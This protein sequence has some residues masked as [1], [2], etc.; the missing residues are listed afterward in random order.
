[1]H[2]TIGAYAINRNTAYSKRSSTWTSAEAIDDEYKYALAKRASPF[3]RVS[4]V[5]EFND[6]DGFLAKVFTDDALDVLN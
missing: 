4:L 3:E 6:V 1:M 5:P 2:G